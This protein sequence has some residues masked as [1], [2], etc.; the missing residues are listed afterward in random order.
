MKDI[1]D[2]H[3]FL[4]VQVVRT[5]DMLFLSQ[6]KYLQDLLTKFQIHKFKPARTLLPSRIALSLIDRDLL[7]DPTEYR[8]MVG[9]LQYL[10]MTRPDI[11]YKMNLVSQFMHAARTAH[12]S[13]VQHIFR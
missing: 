2:L 10:T 12:L 5:P 6:H 9:A 4:G 1:G 7:S 11:S 8:S 13:M 3:Y